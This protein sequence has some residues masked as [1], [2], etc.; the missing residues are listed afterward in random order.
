MNLKERWFGRR[1]DEGEPSWVGEEER[2]RE[3][4]GVLEPELEGEERAG[5]EKRRDS[6]CEEAVLLVGTV[7]SVLA[8]SVAA[9]EELE[10]GLMLRRKVQR[11]LPD[12][13][14]AVGSGRDVIWLSD[15]SEVYFS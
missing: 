12:G 10:K 7:E 15:S 1:S 8:A 4:V 13:V 3:A 14:L 9:D 11:F 5:G 6:R 2:E